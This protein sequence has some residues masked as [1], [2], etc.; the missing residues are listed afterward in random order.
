[1]S[2]LRIRSHDAL[3]GVLGGSCIY[4]GWVLDPTLHDMIP[5]EFIF[6]LFQN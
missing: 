5:H 1:M 3:L 2:L 6:I 4:I